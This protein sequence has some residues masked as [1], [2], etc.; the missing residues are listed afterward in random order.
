MTMRA[1]SKRALIAGVPLLSLLVAP[2]GA[3]HAV[4]EFATPPSPRLTVNERVRMRIPEAR[5]LQ[6]PDLVGQPVGAA[7]TTLE[8]RGLRA[9][10]VT[11]RP[12]ADHRPGT[13]LAQAP[14]PGTVVEPGTA[15]NLWVAAAPPSTGTRVPDD[16]PSRPE[17]SAADGQRPPRP[18][19]PPAPPRPPRLAVVPDLVTRR[20]D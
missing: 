9:G 4:D 7:R 13:V 8:T 1:I 15:I 11:S 17:G 5:I 10:R 19:P 3:A 2:L 6:A 14:K 18:V 12:T 16:R 20:L